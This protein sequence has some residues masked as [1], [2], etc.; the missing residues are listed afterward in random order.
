[1]RDS[2]SPPGGSAVTETVY[3]SPSRL[4]T[5][6]DCQRKYDHSYVK[7]VTTPDQTRLYLNQGR[8]YHETIEAVC[9]AT[10][11]DDDADVIH[12]R[13]RDAFD[14]KWD[15]HVDPGEYESRA[16]REYQRAE[17]RA[18]IDAFFSPDG[19][20]GIRHARRSVATE[21][22]LECLHEGVGLHGYADNILQTDDGL[23]VIDYKRTVRGVITPY[24]AKYLE[25]HLHGET[26]E[27]KRVKNVFQT[28]TY[29]EGVKQSALYDPGMDIQFSFYGLVHDTD[30]TSTPEG[31][32]ITVNG[33]ERSTTGVYA[34]YYD[35]VWELIAEAHSG[36]TSGD[37]VPAPFALINEEA[38]PDCEYREM[39]PEYLAAEVH[40]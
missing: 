36:I 4:A 25:Q 13:A 3:L 11:P 31:F 40:R 6:A 15:V 28:A 1:V 21:K 29:V 18:A 32:D 5:Y 34:E 7:D 17:N 14:E 10:D 38:C 27:P 23:H 16:H 8:A 22:W 39:C 24:T 9:D 19:G 30:V 35:T 26:H 20:D 12:Q 33:K 37:H 2:T